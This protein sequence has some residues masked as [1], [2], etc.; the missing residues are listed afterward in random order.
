MLVQSVAMPVILLLLLKR[1]CDDDNP[2]GS[3]HSR[4][5][6][7]SSNSRAVLLKANEFSW[8]AHADKARSTPNGTRSSSGIG[9]APRMRQPAA[10]PI[11]RERK[12]AAAAGN[13][14]I[15]HQKHCVSSSYSLAGC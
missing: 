3:S 15:L 11:A 7:S 9:R 12:R 10:R 8:L 5:L 14:R 13:L 4:A 2:V 6:M 1:D